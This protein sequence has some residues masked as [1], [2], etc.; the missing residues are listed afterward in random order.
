VQICTRCQAQSPDSATQCNTCQAD[1]SE[2]SS[3]SAALKRFRENTRVLY[4]RIAVAGDCCPACREI[5]GA[6]P[7]DS[8]PHL[9]VEGCSHQ[10]GCRC[11]YQPFLDEIYP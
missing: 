7:K 8:V 11:F 10:H 6:Y 4:V 5:Q 3:T 9:P 2:W 1:F